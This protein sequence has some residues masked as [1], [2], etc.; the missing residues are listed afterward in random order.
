MRYGFLSLNCK[1]C[2]PKEYLTLTIY[3][4][5][6]K[7]VTKSDL[8]GERPTQFGVLALKNFLTQSLTL[9]FYSFKGKLV[10]GGHLQSLTCFR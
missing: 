1:L 6:S 2:G 8:R 3:K 5:T 9:F 4:Q 7:Y 10:F